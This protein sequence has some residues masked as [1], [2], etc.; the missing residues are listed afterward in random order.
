MTEQEAK[1]KFKALIEINEHYGN[2]ENVE[3]FSKAIE[4][5]EKQIPKKPLYGTVRSDNAVYCSE[6]SKF[7][8]FCDETFLPNFCKHCGQAIKWQ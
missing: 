3:L 4:T 2:G 8:G 6:C 7:V 5:L 1:N